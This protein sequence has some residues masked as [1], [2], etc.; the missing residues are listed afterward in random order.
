MY[1]ALPKDMLPSFEL[2]ITPTNLDR[3]KNPVPDDHIKIKNDTGITINPYPIT[4]VTYDDITE[5]IKIKSANSIT[6]DI[7]LTGTINP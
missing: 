3:I 5:H 2:D 7:T 4:K 6:H 1:G